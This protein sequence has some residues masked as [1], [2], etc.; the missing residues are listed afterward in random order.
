M[1]AQLTATLQAKL[2]STNAAV[3]AF[4]YVRGGLFVFSDF[5]VSRF[6]LT[7]IEILC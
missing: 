7:T 6:I 3:S 2:S 5:D 1:K 4:R